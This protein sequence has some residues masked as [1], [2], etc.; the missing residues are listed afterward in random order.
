MKSAFCCNCLKERF[1]H[2]DCDTA[3]PSPQFFQSLLIFTLLNHA[4][5]TCKTK[6]IFTIHLICF[7]FGNIVNCA[8]CSQSNKLEWQI[9]VTSKKRFSFLTLWI[10]SFVL[11]FLQSYQPFF[12]RKLWSETRKLTEHADRMNLLAWL[13]WKQKRANIVL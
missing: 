1:V 2:R 6:I 4:H 12:C 7:N 10:G 8:L 13:A 5:A 9:V 11:L 3:A